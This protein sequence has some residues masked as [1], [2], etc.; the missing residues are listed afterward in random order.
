M[1]AELEANLQGSESR[2]TNMQGATEELARF[3]ANTRDIPAKRKTDDPRYGRSHSRSDARFR[4]QT[5][6]AMGER[7]R[8]RASRDGYRAGILPLTS[9]GGSCQWSC[10]ARA[11]L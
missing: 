9:A 7:S 5:P 4:L 8:E 2:G 6:R 3:V 1:K 10:G 11:G